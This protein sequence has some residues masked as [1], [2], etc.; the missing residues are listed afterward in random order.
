MWQASLNCLA[1][2][3]GCA[4]LR[5]RQQKGS[6]GLVRTC[7]RFS[8][9]SGRAVM[10]PEELWGAICVGQELPPSLCS[11]SPRSLF[12]CFREER[13]H[14]SLPFCVME[15]R[16]GGTLNL[17]LL[18]ISDS[19]PLSH[20]HFPVRIIWEFCEKN[21]FSLFLQP[22]PCTF[23]FAAFSNMLHQLTLCQHFPSSWNLLTPVHW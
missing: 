9:W 1:S 3:V 10:V 15:R 2:L 21:R 5:R 12:N 8:D 7:W 18:P 13:S 17:R 20:S 11:L 23:I 6:R 19:S 4:L 22:P 14:H 16:L